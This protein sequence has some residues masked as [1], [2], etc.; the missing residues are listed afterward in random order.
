MK[1]IW[2]LMLVAVLPAGAQE[3]EKPQV[4]CTLRT[5][6]AIAR[7]V[8]GDVFEY[9]SLARPDEDPHRVSAT[10]AL[11]NR[12]RRAS[13]F[14]EIGLSLEIWADEVANNSRNPRI[15]RGA[16]GRVVVS[17]GI[18]REEVPTGPVTR[19]EGDLHPEGNPHLWLD[20]LR[21]KEI[22]ARMAEAMARA[23]PSAAEE[24]RSRQRRFADRIDEAMFGKELLDIV[25]IK[26]LTRLAYDGKLQSYLA[27]KEYEGRKLSGIAG[28]WLKKAA[29]LAGVKAVEYHPVWVY[30][31]KRFGLSL[32]GTVE[33]KPGIPPG[34]RH[35]QELADRIRSEKVRL[36]LVD[37]YFDPSLPRK[38]AEETGAK[39]VIVPSQVG[40]EPGTETYFALIDHLLDR[41]LEA[42]R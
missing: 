36:L 12:V 17:T 22:A 13:L 4:V 6:E 30:F 38:L 39:L 15:F 42:A 41:M 27:E 20:P 10:P 3:T 24:I 8:G 21:A 33:E 2:M 25:G 34:P 16:A 18:P 35:R 23:A 26:A 31:A 11:W 5:L 40:G 32:S 14:F 29:P 19:A 37:N 9:A 7:E 28:G 1:N